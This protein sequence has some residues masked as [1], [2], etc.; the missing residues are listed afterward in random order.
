MP[1]VFGGVTRANIERR[2]WPKVIKT[3]G[4]WE[5]IGAKTSGGYGSLWPGFKVHRLAYELLV[6]SVPD[7]LVL[8]HLCR[9]RAC[10]NPAHM[11]PVTACENV[12]RGCGPT[13][14]L[15]PPR[16]AC[17]RGHPFDAENTYLWK[18][19]ARRCKTCIRTASREY[20]RRLRARAA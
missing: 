18:D 12:A 14:R 8:D 3:D 13:G 10:V 17:K 6:G 7:G 19:G 5:W 4:C 1:E 16:T 20:Q 15:R 9:N 11:E 2:F